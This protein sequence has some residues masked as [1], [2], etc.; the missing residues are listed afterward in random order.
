[1]TYQSVA[2]L[3]GICAAAVLLA[4][5]AQPS[6]GGLSRDQAKAER[7]AFLATHDYDDV[8][9]LWTPKPG[10]AVKPVPTESRAQAKAERDAFLSKNKYDDMCVCFKP[11]GGG[12]RDVST[13]SRDEVKA[14]TAEFMRTHTFDETT[15]K[16]VKKKARRASRGFRPEALERRGRGRNSRGSLTTLR[17][18]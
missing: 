4:S 6:G 9:G 10:A 7:D 13:M 11:I 8:T 18:R 12:S 14:E 1:M 3:L 2:R 15:G 17:P 5:C 16:W